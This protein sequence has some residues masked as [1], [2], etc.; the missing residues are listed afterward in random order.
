MDGHVFTA[1]NHRSQ[2][3]GHEARLQDQVGGLAEEH[4]GFGDRPRCPDRHPDTE[5]RGWP[6]VGQS[7]YKYNIYIYIHTYIYVYLCI[8]MYVCIYIYV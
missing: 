2:V 4:H 1:C 7:I 6:H 8:F 3:D 5:L